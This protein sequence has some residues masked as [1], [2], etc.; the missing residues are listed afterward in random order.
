MDK[1]DHKEFRLDC[2][3]HHPLHFVQIDWDRWMHKFDNGAVEDE[4]I[5]LFFCSHRIGGFWKRVWRAFKYVFGAQE[6]VT[7]DICISKE[8][9]KELAVFLN[10]V[11]E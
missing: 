7:G 8:K 6:L 4:D 10:E 1:D 11:A 9:A 3:C 5:N 2:D